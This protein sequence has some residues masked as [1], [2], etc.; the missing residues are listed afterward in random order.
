MRVHLFF[1]PL[2]L[3]LTAI[4]IHAITIH[5]PGDQPTIQAGID[6][7]IDGDTVLVADG[8]YTGDGNRNIDFSGKAIVVMSENGPEVT[9]IDC[10][11]VGRGFSFHSGEAA[12]S[13]VKGF[14]ISNG[15]AADWGG[16]IYCVLSSP[17]IANCTFSGNKANWGG[18]G[19]MQNSND[20]SPQVT[21]CTFSGN[22]GSLEG[23]GMHNDNS[24][25][26]VTNCTFS[27]NMSWDDGGGM[28]NEGSNPTVA[29]CTFSSNHSDYGGGMANREYS[30][31]TITNCTFSEN[32]G[33]SFSGM[34]NSYSSPTITNCILWGNG[35][36]GF[37]NSGGSNPTVT[38]SNIQGGFPGEGNIDADPRFMTYKGYDYLLNVTSPCIDT[39]DPSI[40]D[41][42]SDWHPRWPDWLPNGSRS[43]MGAY[44]GPGNKGWLH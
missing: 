30:N 11:N 29:N 28:Y 38:Y 13:V 23:G 21:N 39:G 9:I 37:F 15:W 31:P 5:V 3:L 8:T 40:E 36:Q 4:P 10:E 35:P 17:T 41:G 14:T 22:H 26:M 24:S 12:T 32:L 18:G 6:V 34:F 20:S 33:N 25:P 43:D 7:S 2:V 16:G 1:L 42:I 27:G 44:G 19:G